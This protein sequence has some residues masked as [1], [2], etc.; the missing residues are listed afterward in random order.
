MLHKPVLDNFVVSGVGV[1]LHK[2]VLDNFVVWGGRG[3]AWRDA[4]HRRFG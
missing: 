1:L 4:R 3:G 2:P